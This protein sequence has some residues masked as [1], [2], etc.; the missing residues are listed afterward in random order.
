M[1]EAE[2]GAARAQGAFDE[3]INKM[4]D[5]MRDKNRSEEYQKN[6]WNE[7]DR[8]MGLTYNAW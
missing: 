5:E 6:F 7:L 4:R 1:S 2:C 3:F 8:L